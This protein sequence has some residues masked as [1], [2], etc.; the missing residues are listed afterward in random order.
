MINF[1]WLI[2]LFPTVAALINGLFGRK[3]MRHHYSD[4]I[5][6]GAVM[7]SFLISLIVFFEVVAGARLNTD[8]WDWIVS[9][10]FQ[11]SFGFMIDPLTAI[12][13]VVVT[14]IS[15]LI[16]LY[17][18]GYMHDD[19]GYYRFFTYLSMFTVSMLIL[20]MGNNYLLMF[21]GWEGVGLCSYLLI[22]FWFEKKSAGDASKK[23][24]VT[25]RV[26]DLGFVLGLFLL[27]TQLGTLDYVK[28]FELAH[29]GRLSVEA[30]TAITL[31]LFIG[32]TAKSAQI[33]LYTWL[34]DAMEGPTPVSALIHAA[35]MVT[36]GVYMVA[37]SHA[38]YHLAPFTMEVVAVVGAVTA[39]FAATIATAQNDIKRVVAYSTV[40]HLG[41]MFMGL[42]LGAYT[43]GIY[44]LFTHA[45]FKACL[46]LGAGS[47]IHALSGEQ[48]IRKMGGLFPLIKVTS[49][50]F[51]IAALANAGIFPFAGFFS[52]DEILWAAFS[53]GHYFLWAIGATAAFCSSFYMFRLF[54]LTFTGESR[55]D[56]HVAHHIHESPKVMTVP[57]VILAFLATTVGAL[58]VPPG[59]GFIHNFLEPVFGAHEVELK[60]VVAEFFHKF[61]ALVTGEPTAHG[62]LLEYFMMLVSLFIAISGIGIS[63]LMYYKKVE[64]LNPDVLSQR[65]RLVYQAFLNKYWVD[66]LYDFLFVN[67]T[68]KAGQ[69]LWDFDGKVVDGAV[70]GTSWIAL[71]KAEITNFTDKYVVDGTVNGIALFVDL[72]SRVLR[73]MQTGDVQNYAL[74][75]LLGVV[76]VMGVYYFY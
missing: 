63:Y 8:Y 64:A 29:E 23:A 13:L 69:R 47:V 32:A 54:F 19:E 1:A 22:G 10:D 49:V 9:G 72:K 31:L 67:P 18:I 46:F 12:M 5:A 39:L 57:L 42:G 56:E 48:D 71:I 41:Y 33:P 14:G 30:A 62:H 59:A 28:A 17:S 35:T 7:T 34:P 24:F 73:R 27:F 37:R 40:S 58:A 25:N 2:P 43:A 38:I 11:V 60:G 68:K 52:K 65:F 3:Y 76:F 16:H 75:M 21:L 4:Y 55:V 20:V 15:S 51:L 45:F 74:V 61:E 53:G 6:T 26:G 36:A 50:T 66:E 44:H 70:N